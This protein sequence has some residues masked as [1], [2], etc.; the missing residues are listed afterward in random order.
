VPAKHG[1]QTV[2]HLVFQCERLEND[3]DILKNIVLKKGNWPLSKSEL[4]NR[5]FK[6]FIRYINSMDFEKINRSNEQLQMNTNNRNVR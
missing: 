4:N 2:D 5:N 6:Q 3:R 1:I